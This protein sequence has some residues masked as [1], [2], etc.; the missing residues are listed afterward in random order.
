[1]ADGMEESAETAVSEQKKKRERTP[2]SETHQAFL[3]ACHAFAAKPF[4]DQTKA[5][6]DA[7]LAHKRKL[8]GLDTVTL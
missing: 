3:D 5:V 8:I 2:R 7:M 6:L 4:A 1:M